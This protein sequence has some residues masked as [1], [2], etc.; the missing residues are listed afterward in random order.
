MIAY[1]CGPSVLGYKSPW[2][3]GGLHISPVRKMN[4]PACRCEQ[5]G[6]CCSVLCASR[7][8]DLELPGRGGRAADGGL[9][10]PSPVP[11]CCLNPF[12]VTPWSSCSGLGTAS[13]SEEASVSADWDAG[14]GAV[15]CTPVVSAP[16][17]LGRCED[18]FL[19]FSLAGQLAAA[20]VAQVTLLSLSGSVSAGSALSVKPAHPLSHTP[21]P[22]PAPPHHNGKVGL[23]APG[24]GSFSRTH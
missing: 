6:H 16:R 9:A 18:G 4:S 15:V 17:P 3:P 19:R 23:Q 10:P 1:P 5:I 22:H 14:R 21:S 7:P 20:G 2:Q 12:S 13:G 8:R 24:L 11:T